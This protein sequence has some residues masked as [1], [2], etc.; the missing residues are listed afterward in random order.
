MH[1]IQHYFY[2]L[3][4]SLSFFIFS[5]CSNLD[6][7]FE[8]NSVFH[9]SDKQKKLENSVVNVYLDTSTKV[10]DKFRLVINGE[11]TELDLYYDV[12]TR[13]GITKQNTSIDLLKNNIKVMS[14]HLTLVD[15]KNYFLVVKKDE[16]SQLPVILEV[17]KHQISK[18]TKATPIFVSEEVVKA[19][20]IKQIQ[21][22]EKKAVEK[23]E[24]FLIKKNI[25]S[26]EAKEEFVAKK[27]NQESEKVLNKET[28][29]NLK[30]TP[31]SSKKSLQEKYE[32]GEAI[33]YYDPD[34][35]E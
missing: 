13:F 29:N 21:K 20:K 24:D 31:V 8:E 1:T 9:S 27:S 28:K 3:V 12:L 22:I 11:D 30:R 35:G 6:V 33:F 34:D 25:G 2:I 15:K 23:K 5:G 4:F 19:D 14:L 16:K 7:G 18:G 32:A 26:K 17:D 10:S